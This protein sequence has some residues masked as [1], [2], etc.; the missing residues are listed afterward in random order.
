M[1]NSKK[2]NDKAS[3]TDDERSPQETERIREAT[4]KRILSTPPKPHKAMIAERRAGQPKRSNRKP[5][6]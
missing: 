1:T 4:L 2:P 6:R 5:Q 3:L